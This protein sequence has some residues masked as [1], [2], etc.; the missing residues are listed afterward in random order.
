MRHHGDAERDQLHNPHGPHQMGQVPATS[1]HSH[2]DSDRLNRFHFISLSDS[3]ADG[4][5]EVGD[6]LNDPFWKNGVGGAGRRWK[7][8]KIRGIGDACDPRHKDCVETAQ[9]L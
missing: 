7:H 4:E 8:W 5:E 1:P 2:G 3:P 6:I 9:K